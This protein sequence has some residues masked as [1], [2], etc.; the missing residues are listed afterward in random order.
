MRLSPQHDL[1][2]PDLSARSLDRIVVGID[3]SEVSLGAAQWV[4]RHLARNATLTL[5]HVIP[6]PPVPNAL[7]L[8]PDQVANLESRLRVRMQS[9]RGALHGLAGV[10]G[11]TSAGVEVRVGDP[12]VQ[13]SAYANMVDADLLVVGGNSEFH[14]APRHETATTDRLLRRLARPGL[15]A[16]NVQ[17]APKTVLVALTHDA[18]ASVLDVARMVAAPSGAR[19]VPLRLAERG[20]GKD[21]SVSVTFRDAAANEQ[22]RMIVDVARELRA[23]VIVIG[24]HASATSDDDDIARLLA[25]TANCSVLVVPHPTVPRPR[26]LH[27][28]APGHVRRPM[29][30]GSQPDDANSPRPAATVRGTD[31]AA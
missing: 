22:V 13:L 24:S 27:L 18:A 6:P 28:D 23:D 20:A 29:A 10:I 12:A 8:R 3:F 17:S 4:G 2:T 5:V 19:V 25:R 30:V 26:R 1:I 14:V 7:R 31:D 21:A 11:G 16:R 15:V 9:M